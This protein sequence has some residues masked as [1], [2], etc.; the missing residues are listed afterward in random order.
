MDTPNCDYTAFHL[1]VDET[2]T[3]THTALGGITDMTVVD[4]F[5]YHSQLH[6]AI[7]ISSSDAIRDAFPFFQYINHMQALYQPVIPPNAHATSHKRK[8]AVTLA[9]HLLPC[10]LPFY[11]TV[12]TH[13]TR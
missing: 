4:W 1:R 7:F 12:G 2:H 6:I 3:T 10:A 5:A 13:I 9:G 11:S 8:S